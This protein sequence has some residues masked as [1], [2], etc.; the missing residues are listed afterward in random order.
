MRGGAK[1][2]IMLGAVHCSWKREIRPY[3]GYEMWNRLLC[4]DR[5]WFYLVTH[6]VKKG[7]VRP[8][9][10]TLD[11]PEDSGVLPSWT[12]SKKGDPVREFEKATQE[13]DESVIF[14]SSISKYVMKLGRLTLH[15]EAILDMS[16][17]LPPKPGGWNTMSRPSTTP[18][19]PEEDDEVQGTL[20]E[21]SVFTHMGVANGSAEDG[22]AKVVEEKKDGADPG[23]TWEMIEAEN[24]KGMELAKNFQ[25]LDMLPAT[26][27]GPTQPAIG[28]YTDL[29]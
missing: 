7:A 28:Y 26:F 24:A 20:M 25:N 21:D 14:A 18:G 13:V 5:K 8:N 19:T 15:P 29:F 27:T 12:R 17:L 16:G 4:W 9:G 22:A 6:F 10:Y 2:G 23:W 11:R 3:E 1:W